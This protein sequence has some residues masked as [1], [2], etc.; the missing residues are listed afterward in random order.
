MSSVE[1]WHKCDRDG[2]LTFPQRQLSGRELCLSLVSASPFSHLGHNVGYRLPCVYTKYGNAE[3]VSI[4]GSGRTGLLQHKDV[5][6]DT[7]AFV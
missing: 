7:S 2:S 4:N 6:V 1:T 3:S 5:I